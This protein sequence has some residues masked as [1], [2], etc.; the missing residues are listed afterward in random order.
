MK[1]I[2]ISTAVNIMGTI[3]AIS[4]IALVTVSV[5]AI[6]QLKVGGPIYNQIVLGK[7]LAADILP[8]PEY[9]IESYLEATLSLSD[10]DKTGVHRERLL[11]L[12][13]DYD[14]RHTYWSGREIPDGIKAKLVE[15]SHSYVVMFFDELNSKFV[16]ALARGDSAGAAQSHSILTKIYSDHRAVIDEVVK[17]TD[18]F[19]TNTESSAANQEH[20]LSSMEFIIAIIA[21]AIVVASIFLLIRLVIRPLSGMTSVMNELSRGNLDV[22][23]PSVGRH[24]EIGDMAQALLV[25]KKNG[26][27]NQRLQAAKDAD[28]KA[29]FQRQQETDE[30]FDMFGASVSGVFKTL[31]HASQNLADTAESMKGAVAQTNT[32]IGAVAVEVSEAGTNAQSVA[33]A[34]QEL[35]SAI[36][37]ISRLVNTSSKVAEQGS[38]QASDVAARVIMLRDASEKIGNIIGIISDIASQTNLLAL[39]ATIEAARA[40]AAGKGFAVV[41]NEVKSLSNQTQKA[42]IEI[43]AQINEIQSAIGGTVQAVQAIGDTVTEIYQS[44]AEIAAAITEQQS[45]TDEIARNI[46]FVS[47][48][49]DRISASM[50]L[51]S[52]SANETNSSSIQ[53]HD[54]SASMSTQTDKLSIEIK[55][56]LNAVRGAGQNHHFERIAVNGTAS[57]S[58]AGKSQNVHIKEL[59]IAGAWLDMHLDQP[60]GTLVELSVSGVQKLIRARIAGHSDKGTRLQFPMDGQHLAGMTE[61]LS[62]LRGA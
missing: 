36:A 10:H 22:E 16:P 24:D 21:M 23:A 27:E 2:K 45:A 4:V 41:A 32:Q 34:S 55:D 62:K 38:T 15:K 49:T 19:T 13:K 58:Y 56:F 51:V 18:Q 12:K 35:T 54:A 46:E 42:T 48:A 60:L 43:E 40:G 37:E 57:I 28:E 20:N 14:E 31:S 5:I 59:S 30:L 1:S 44:S 53:V 7:D 61:A 47:A 6:S 52:V 33:A 39:N 9:I 25:F 50:S 26:I 29:K 11:Q 8:P 17:D 3:L